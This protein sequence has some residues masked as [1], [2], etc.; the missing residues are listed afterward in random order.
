MRY[1]CVITS[2]MNLGG[3][4]KYYPSVT[5]P[6]VLSCCL[7][8][9]SCNDSNNTVASQ[10][11]LE[12][13]ADP[14]T[15]AI[16]DPIE[17][18]LF[19]NGEYQE[20]RDRGNAALAGYS[21]ESHLQRA[22]ALVPEGAFNGDLDSLTIDCTDRGS[23]AVAQTLS[24]EPNAFVT[25]RTHQFATCE[26]D[27]SVFSGSLTVTTEQFGIGASERATIAQAFSLDIEGVNGGQGMLSMSGDLTTVELKEFNTQSSCPPADTARLE[28]NLDNGGTYNDPLAGLLATY[29]ALSFTRSVADRLTETADGCDVMVVTDY[30]AEARGSFGSIAAAPVSI[31]K[32]GVYSDDA[33]GDDDTPVVFQIKAI[34]SPNRITV[35]ATYDAPMAVQVD[36][37]DMDVIQSFADTWNFTD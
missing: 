14:A 23:V 10:G 8:L 7:A 18:T 20:V 11:S 9:A 22:A 12:D 31:S 3:R 34:D 33:I 17:S 1:A 24:T 29:Q 13:P 25:T 5:T 16:E 26:Q 36:I 35:T 37:V 28:I 32:N 2:L 30:E 27:G 4:M 6:L 21:L 15:T 19:F